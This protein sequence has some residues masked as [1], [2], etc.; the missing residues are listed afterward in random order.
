MPSLFNRFK[1]YLPSLPYMYALPKIHKADVPLRPIIAS[2]NSVTY[3]LSK[4]LSSLLKPLL[5]TISGSH[6]IN[7]TDFVEKIR[8]ID[9]TDKVMVSFDVD[10]L[11]TNVPIDETLKFLEDFL[12]RSGVQLPFSVEILLNLLRL[13]VTNCNFTCNEKFY[14]QISGLPMGSCLSPVL[15]N[16]FM[17][18]FEQFL[19]PSIVDFNIVWYRYVDDVFAVL[20]GD[21]DIGRFLSQLNNLSPTINFKVEN[22]FNNALN[23]LD[24]TIHRDSNNSPRFSI[25]RKP[26]HSN[27]YIHSF[28][29]HANNVKLGAI[30]SIFLRAYRLCDPEFIDQEIAFITKVF[31]QLGYDYNFINRAHYKARRTYYAPPDIERQKFDRVAVLPAVCE[32]SRDVK[33]LFPSNTRIVFNNT[34]TT[35][36]FLRHP[37]TKSFK[38]DACI[39]A[40]PCSECNLHYIGESDN[41]DRR[42]V[43]HRNDMRRCDERNS[44][45]KHVSTKNH[46]VLIS[47]CNIISRIN[48]VHTRK[49]VESFLIKN[50]ENMNSYEVSVKID[51]VTSE[52]LNKN[53]KSLNAL[54]NKLENG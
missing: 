50:T 35:R 48:N 9:L 38:S 52:L 45:F 20:P 3:S 23:F 39:Y 5:G 14:R 19:L 7:S 25:Y 13:C 37:I 2:V 27:L 42:M 26:T 36:S 6:I 1:S 41:I 11:F 10:S 17:E 24:V 44:I 31:S 18:Y 53:V 32:G 33:H 8:G 51:N 29:N 49:L 47:D 34:D 16:I 43:Q 15:S 40:I 54:L 12:P 30:T 22:E 46:N 21:I 28:S 4:Y